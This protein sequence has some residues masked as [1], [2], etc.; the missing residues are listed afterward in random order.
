MLVQEIQQSDRARWKAMDKY[1]K[2]VVCIFYTKIKEQ[3]KQKSTLKI[4]KKCEHLPSTNNQNKKNIQKNSASLQKSKQRKE[5]IK[6]QHLS[7]HPTTNKNQALPCSAATK[8]KYPAPQLAPPKQRN[9]HFHQ[10]P[11]KK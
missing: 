7:Q 3:I 9:R 4:D 8:R 5:Q 6:S 2:T 1:K 10:A 11:N